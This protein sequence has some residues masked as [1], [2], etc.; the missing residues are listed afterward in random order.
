[1]TSDDPP[2]RWFARCVSNGLTA[3]R[4]IRLKNHP[5][6]DEMAA[7]IQVWIEVLW[8][9]RRWVPED[10]ERINESM[11]LV[12]ES[13]ECWPSPAQFFRL[14]PQRVS[15][16]E[17]PSPTISEEKRAVVKARLAELRRRILTTGDAREKQFGLA[18][19]FP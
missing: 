5:G 15:V 13:C 18:R 1:M 19:K 17:L 7:C 3:M 12:M 11:R 10:E 6:Q 9:N 14:L 8:R 2:R 16:P 4:A